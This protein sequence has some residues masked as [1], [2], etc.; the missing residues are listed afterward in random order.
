MLGS[1]DRATIANAVIY[2]TIDP[3]EPE[4]GSL[5]AGC[6]WSRSNHDIHL[7]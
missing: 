4:V 7:D 1:G 6:G 3:Q 2:S 5:G